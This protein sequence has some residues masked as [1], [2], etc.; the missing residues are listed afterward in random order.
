MAWTKF[1]SDNHRFLNILL[2]ILAIALVP[3]L[4]INLI[5]CIFSYS[6]VRK[7][8]LLSTG[9]TL[10]VTSASVDENIKGLEN[11]IT[12]M[13]ANEDIISFTV[14]PEAQNFA[15]NARIMKTL[16]AIVGSYDFVSS[17]Y[18][19]S[20]V[21]G[22]I[23]ASNSGLEY[24]N[25][26]FDTSWIDDFNRHFLGTN[27]LPTR[28]TQDQNNK[29]V[30]IISLVSNLPKG[31]WSKSAGLII[32]IDQN[33]LFEK[34]RLN[35]K[36]DQIA[37]VLDNNGYVIEHSAAGRIGNF[38]GDSA[39]FWN[40]ASGGAGFFLLHS[41]KEKRIVSYCVAPYTHWV[42]VNELNL[43]TL[44][45]VA[46]SAL[47]LNLAIILIVTATI[48]FISLKISNLMY[49]PVRQLTDSTRKLEQVRPVVQD[50]ML[51]FLIH[52]RLKRQEEVNNAFEMLEIKFTEGDFFALVFEIDH[53]AQLTKEL[54]QAELEQLKN[55]F[56]H[57][58]NS[59]IPAKGNHLLGSTG[60]AQLTL[61]IHL[62]EPRENAADEVAHFARRQI[63]ATANTDRVTLSCGIS[64]PFSALSDIPEAYQQAQ[65]AVSQRLYSG[66]NTLHSYQ[67]LL[68]QQNQVF[69]F[70][71]DL[72]KHLLAAVRSGYDNEIDGLTRELIA[73]IK[74]RHPLD[75]K[76]TIQVFN[77]IA[78]TL[79]E[80]QFSCLAALQA[81]PQV[82]DLYSQ[83]RDIDTLEQSAGW[84]SRVCR[85]TAK[86]V[87]EAQI[88]KINVNAKRISFYIDANL[89]KNAISLNDI[90]E[91]VGL[92]PS[93]VSRIFKEYYGTNYVD[94]LNRNR[95]EKAKEYIR[96]SSL[97]IQE[98][99][100]KCG[101][102]SLQT[103]IRVFKKY[104]Q[105][106]P[107][108]YRASLQERP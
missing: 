81:E 16:N 74:E 105:I 64:S 65:I 10:A 108:K 43:A 104:E 11:L 3:I 90:G 18:I 35:K 103:F 27:R 29:S 78:T 54:S 14:D 85:E 20:S 68:K 99:A 60:P 91:A 7:N 86:M 48:L 107:G 70:G 45:G 36:T 8:Y 100:L 88:D 98:I 34:F 77:R 71:P 37:M 94:Y 24:V 50:N 83:I 97:T 44:T 69:F 32:N 1:K 23:I 41:G 79:M 31:S 102:S 51:F 22:L 93:Y 19:Y 67:Q 82:P 80:M 95:I 13:S 2:P 66:S 59:S 61:L 39:L 9:E 73:N 26:F 25:N 49:R 58:I 56:I 76:A 33:K 47:L 5:F 30:P 15:R 17:I 38:R 101:F 12:V 28:M 53:Y 6:F 55:E 21:K 46:R 62:D 92:S 106:A 57:H 52:Q 87:K 96:D 63:T 89:E 75:I 84:L 40:T 4:L 72:E 42:F